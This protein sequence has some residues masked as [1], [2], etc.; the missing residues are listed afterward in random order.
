MIS[1]IIPSWLIPPERAKLWSILEEG[2]LVTK[3]SL[4]VVVDAV[5]TASKG[6]A[7]GIVMRLES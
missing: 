5:D 6:L 3:T 7:A 2:K 4:Q 1:I